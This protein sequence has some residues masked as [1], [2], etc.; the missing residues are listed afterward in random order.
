M[1][2]LQLCRDR[3]PIRLGFRRAALDPS[4]NDNTL[5]VELVV[6]GRDNRRNRE[7]SLREELDQ[8]E[9]PS[10]RRLASTRPTNSERLA[11]AR[12]SPHFVAVGRSS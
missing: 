8:L 4:L 3:C 6:V 9:F 5:M 2:W 1:E 12:R 7:P 11:V 10:Q